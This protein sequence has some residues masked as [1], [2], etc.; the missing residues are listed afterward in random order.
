LG[1]V[2]GKRF[3]LKTTDERFHLA[4]SWVLTVLALRLLYSGVVE[5]SA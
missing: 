4:L 5:A 2:L 1:T 3:L